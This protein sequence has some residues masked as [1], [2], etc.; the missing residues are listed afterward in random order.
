MKAQ[1]IR[2]DGTGLWDRF[3]FASLV[4]KFVPPFQVNLC[5][6]QCK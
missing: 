3:M 6:T 5:K 4:F 1:L 2:G